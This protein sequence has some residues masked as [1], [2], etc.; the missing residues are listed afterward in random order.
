MRYIF[1]RTKEMIMILV[2]LSSGNIFSFSQTYNFRNFNV[3]Q[4]LP[5]K[6]A[7]TI[8]QDKDGFIW[9]GTGNGLCRFD[10]SDF[11][12]GSINDS[13][14][15]GFPVTDLTTG[16]KTIYFGYSDGRLLYE[17]D[18]QLSEIGSLDANRIND[19]IADTRG[20]IY[21]VSQMKGLYMIDPDANHSVS[22]LV[23][24][25]DYSLYAACFTEEGDLLLGTQQGLVLAGLNDMV[26]KVIDEPEEFSYIKVQAIERLGNSNR[27]MVG[28]EGEGLFIVEVNNGRIVSTR[29]DNELL[30]YLRVQSIL[31]VEE[32]T[33]WVATF[34]D[35]LLKLT[36]DEGSGKVANIEQFN[37][38]K[39][40]P[41]D[42]IKSIFRD[43]EGNMWIGTFGNGISVLSSDA[44]IFYRPGG[45]STENNIIWVGEFNN[46]IFAGSQQGYYILDKK[47][48]S[49][50]NYVR[51]S[52]ATGMTDIQVYALSDNGDVYF[53]TAG[54]GL[55]VR[56]KSGNIRKI[57]ESR[58]SIEN[59]INDIKIDNG[60]I[61]LATRGGVI[62]VS[63][64]SGN[65]IRYTTTEGLPHNNIYQVMPDGTGKVYVATQGN[66]L[67]TI[68][69]QTGIHSG[70]AVIYGGA[71]NEFQAH[72]IDSEGK[73]WVCTR[74]SGV[75]SFAGDSVWN[76]TAA[77]GL[78]SNYCY[79][80][81][82]TSDDKVWIGHERG[83]SV[84]DQKLNQVR[85]FPD[86][87]GHDEDYNPNA[88]CETSDGLVVMGTT[89]GLMVYD[90]SKD[91]ESIFP[92]QTNIL[93]VTIDNTVQ[94]L[95]GSYLLPYHGR[96]TVKIDFVGIY[97]TD[98]DKVYYRYI[99]DNYD[100]EWSE[101]T[102][103]NS[104]TYRLSDGNYHFRVV[105]YNYD[106]IT[107]N[108]EAGFDL[109]IK[110]PLW[111]MWWFLLLMFILI[112]GL[113]VIIITI[114]DTA[115]RKAKQTL[116]DELANRT[117]EV[118]AQK[119][120]IEQKNR[121]IT[122]SIN[123]AQRIQASLL[124][125]L[126]KLEEA[127]R[128]NFVFFRPR[129]IV[130][131]DFYWFDR[132]DDEKFVLVCADSTGHGVP[133][134]FMSM[135][136]SAL[137][138]EIVTRK[139][140]TRPSEIL[141]TLDREISSTLNQGVDGLS[142]SDGMDVV[143]CEYN[144]KT[145][146]L[147]FASAMRPVILVMDGEQYYIRGNK[148]SV[149][150]E[151]VAEKYF[152]DQEYYLKEN[153]L[154]YLFSDGY[155]DQFGG[156]AGKKLKILRLKRLIDDI[157]GLSMEEQQKKVVDFFDRWKGDL[158]QVDDVLLMALKV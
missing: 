116:E 45:E 13:T 134:A 78:F 141:A 119:E 10:G 51:L 121:E 25:V 5:G 24:P 39:G 84:F 145:R 114:R 56:N 104:C 75:F 71:R 101:S 85:T 144:S 69:P 23:S 70:K 94:P 7:Y 149:G 88:I 151:I 55:F 128:G 35:G 140:I 66:R 111:R 36:I 147:R 108:Q 73:I 107:S 50:K 64:Q 106:G 83:F 3:D 63:Q 31:P 102:F 157:K 41:G 15:T 91:A 18:G 44:F 26:L 113:I 80:I 74:G 135:I 14:S 127:F 136:G 52:G 1:R 137:L 98:P 103:N 60:Y 129:D 155:P 82:C 58:N 67:Y 120:E 89:E 9:I 11:Y 125:P 130:S 28:T 27:Y 122:D 115:Q 33:V 22:K 77:G 148:N 158:D 142:T 90:R 29:F 131:G 20:R 42:D 154:V 133:G 146:L 4:G 61:W 95:N 48:G 126:S 153:D 72:S 110:K 86:I 37:K 76:L 100:T 43:R 46:D 47:G 6:F 97:F 99:L 65:I 62:S 105:S 123:Y 124:P 57:F 16:D 117:V 19:I 49:V 118:R 8:S 87:F 38:E 81:L 139:E 32:N 109:I 138:Q 12:T 156:S 143:V 34:G 152:D 59:Y 92:P 93:S 150:G 17:K 54:S 2:L 132:V 112:I 21:A 68:D 96:Y 30:S 40:L 53:G 79:S